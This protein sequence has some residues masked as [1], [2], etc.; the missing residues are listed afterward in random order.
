MIMR[1]CAPAGWLPA[2][3]LLRCCGLRAG[4]LRAEF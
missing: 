1:S 2:A 3:A 4:G